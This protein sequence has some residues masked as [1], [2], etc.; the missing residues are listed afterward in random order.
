VKKITIFCLK[1]KFFWIKN[2][3]DI[4]YLRNQ[5]RIMGTLIRI[6]VFSKKKDFFLFLNLE[7]VIVGIEIGIMRT[8][9]FKKQK[10]YVLSFLLKNFR[11]DIFFAK[12][13]YPETIQIDM[14]L[15]DKRSDVIKRWREMSE[16]LSKIC[17]HKFNRQFCYF[18]KEIR[19]TK[20]IKKTITGMR[21]ITCVLYLE[22]LIK[23]FK[24]HDFFKYSVYKNFWQRGFNLSCGIK[25]GC[26]FLAYAG[27]IID[28]HS[29]LS[30]LIIPIQYNSITPKLIIAFGRVGTITKKI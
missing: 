26:S 30:I 24:E 20:T 15:H 13:F 11:Q 27:N 9:I 18:K 6:P 21:S 25:F 29:Y 12:N 14:N 3:N 7:E 17:M 19:K 1:N 2:T 16:I 10:K 8:K 4:L 23:H 5:Y 28:V 22:N